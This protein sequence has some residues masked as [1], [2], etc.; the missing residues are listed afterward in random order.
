MKVTMRLTLDGLVRAMRVRAYE[1]AEAVERD[2]AD[3]GRTPSRPERR[4]D[5]RAGDDHDRSSA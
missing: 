4:A 2:E 3:L 5:A 1:L